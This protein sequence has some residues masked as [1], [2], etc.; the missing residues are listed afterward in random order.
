MAKANTLAYYETK[1]NCVSKK[2]YCVGPASF[3]FDCNKV[4]FYQ[5]WEMGLELMQ[6]QGTASQNFLQL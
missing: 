5:M 1:I 2:F 4:N 3:F 6:D